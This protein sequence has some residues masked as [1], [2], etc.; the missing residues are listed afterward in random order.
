VLPSGEMNELYTGHNTE[1]GTRESIMKVINSALEF[2]S[3]CRAQKLT[4]SCD[5]ESRRENEKKSLFGMNLDGKLFDAS[6]EDI[7]RVHFMILLWASR[8]GK[9]MN[10]ESSDVLTMTMKMRK[11]F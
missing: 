5:L 8:I 11:L 9:S 2:S 4:R 1:G 3:L 6:A 10:S 7:C